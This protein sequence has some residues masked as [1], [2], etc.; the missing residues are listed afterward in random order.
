[1]AFDFDIVLTKNADQLFVPLDTSESYKVRGLAGDDV[2]TTGAGDDLIKGGRGQD[3]LDGGA[4][5]DVLRGGRGNDLLQGGSGNDILRGGRGDD[6][7]MGSLGQDTLVGGEGRDVYAFQAEDIGESVAASPIIDVIKG[8]EDGVDRLALQGVSFD[9]SNFSVIWEGDV[10]TFDFGNNGSVDFRVRFADGP[11]TLDASDIYTGSSVVSLSGGGSDAEEDGE[12]SGED[13][14]VDLAI[15]T[16]FSGEFVDLF[17]LDAD[18]VS[19]FAFGEEF[20]AEPVV[21]SAITQTLTVTNNGGGAATDVLVT[22]DL[23]H[24]FLDVVGI[25]GAGVIDLDNDGDPLTGDGDVTT[26]EFLITNLGAGATQTI[27]INLEVNNNFD[28]VAF[29]QSFTLGGSGNDYAGAEFTGTFYSDASAFT[30]TA[31]STEIAFNPF[32]ILGNT[33]TATDGSS[34]A[35]A[36]GELTFL[37]TV[38]E[39][40]LNNGST[41]L[42]KSPYTQTIDLDPLF[43]APLPINNASDL[44]GPGQT[45]IADLLLAFDDLVDPLIL[46][47][48]AATDGSNPLGPNG[49]I[50]LFREAAAAAFSSFVSELKGQSSSVVLNTFDIATGALEATTVFDVIAASITSSTPLP[51]VT[52]LRFELEPGTLQVRFLENGVFQAGGLASQG[53]P[54]PDVGP[55]DIF[56]IDSPDAGSGSSDEGPDPEEGSP[57]ID[58]TFTDALTGIGIVDGD[59][60]TLAEQ[61]LIDGDE[62][63]GIRLTDV[64]AKR[65]F[66]DLENVTSDA[67]LVSGGSIQVETFNAGSLVESQVFTLGSDTPGTLSVLPSTSMFDEVRISAVTG[68]DTS[69]TF[70]GITVDTLTL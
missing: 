22:V 42:V 9:P 10:A 1:M 26:G 59:D 68:S 44:I 70:R 15:A 69:F 16:A 46:D 43:F 41:A 62:I 37:R 48:F 35:S 57:F 25:T 30:K 33:A 55:F 45:G 12:G 11:F 38:L 24:P 36:S 50:T 4:G 49:A 31:G 8:F 54:T 20:V 3:T 60:A 2:I 51:E 34:T 32:P 19:P 29:D 61:Q 39:A 56:A 67:G 18:G 17:V 47:A 27:D 64:L 52:S 5:D 7:L 63:L 53:G 14:E 28:I 23:S 65:A 40:Q 66:I 13:P 6:T 58:T 21:G